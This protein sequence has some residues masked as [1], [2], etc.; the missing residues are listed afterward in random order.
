M[1]RQAFTIAAVAFVCGTAAAAPLVT[2][3]SP[4]EC[5]DYHGKDRLTEKND[6]A[7][8]PTDPNAI[9]AVTPS[10]IFSWQ[11]PTEPLTRSSG[12][13][14]AE[15]KWYAVTGGVVELRAEADGDLHIALQDATG[16]KLGIVVAEIPAKPHKKWTGRYRR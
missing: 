6:T 13:I 4:C 14:A 3:E 1:K 5:R 12:R 11:G 8:P 16:D 2:Y 15:Q 9:Q 10:G 7:L